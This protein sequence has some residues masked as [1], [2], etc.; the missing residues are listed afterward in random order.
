MRQLESRLS[1]TLQSLQRQDSDLRPKSR[2]RHQQQSASSTDSFSDSSPT[3]APRRKPLGSSLKLGGKYDSPSYMTREGTKDTL[4]S[5][6]GLTKPL[7]PEYA[8]GG[9]VQTSG[10]K[11]VRHPFRQSIDCGDTSKFHGLKSPLPQDDE[12]STSCVVM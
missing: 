4:T 12:K 11:V 1:L 5:E 8:N 9:R 3:H 7:A 10:T 6:N 2:A